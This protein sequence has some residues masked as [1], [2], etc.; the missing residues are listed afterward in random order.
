M[1]TNDCSNKKYYKN[2]HRKINKI[3]DEI[4]STRKINGE[5]YEKIK[6]L[7]NFISNH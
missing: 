2:D 7:E 5:L 1:V 6:G 3:E 4:M